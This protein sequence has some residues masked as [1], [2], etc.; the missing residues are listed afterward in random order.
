LQ[1]IPERVQEYTRSNRFDILR[2]RILSFILIV[3]CATVAGVVGYGLLLALNKLAAIL[4]VTPKIGPLDVP[5]LVTLFVVEGLLALISRIFGV[6]DRPKLRVWQIEGTWPHAEFTDHG[7]PVTNL[8]GDGATRCE[9]RILLY[10]KKDHLL[11]LTNKKSVITK[12]TLPTFFIEDSDDEDVPIRWVNQNC[13][14]L[15]I[16]PDRNHREGLIFLRV[17]Y[18]RGKV[19]HFEIPSEKGWKPM[20][21]ALKPNDY[22]GRI[23]VRP[24]NGKPASTSFVIRYDSKKQSV[25]LSFGLLLVPPNLEVNES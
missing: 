23:K 9:A 21:V 12:R 25:H 17:V 22:E 5:T 1:H 14:Q 7:V 18:S 6:S 10:L 20:L 15:D 13:K 19:H 4:E 8:G 2:R 11:T 24:M 16:W 3:C